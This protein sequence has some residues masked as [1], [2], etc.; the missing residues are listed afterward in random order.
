MTTPILRGG[1]AILALLLVSGCADPE[2]PEQKAQRRA[3]EA[4]VIATKPVAPQVVNLPGIGPRTCVG[5][6]PAGL[7]GWG[8][9]L[10]GEYRKAML[11]PAA[12]EAGVRVYT[13]GTNVTEYGSI[14]VQYGT[15]EETCILWTESLTLQE[16]A[17]RLGMNPVGVSP[18][19]E[20]GS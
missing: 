20:P 5:R 18:F 15:K 4:A 14:V 11:S 12:Q 16:Y 3:Q 19:Y 6:R 9:E 17:I 8:K 7:P 1:A 13:S 2:S 10:E